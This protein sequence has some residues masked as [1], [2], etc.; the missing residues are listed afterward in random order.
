MLNVFCEDMPG[1]IF[2]ASLYFNN[3]YKDRWITKPLS[4]DM[5]RDVDKSEVIDERAIWSPVFGYM[6]P[7]RLSGG[8][9]TL[10][11]I[12]NDPSHIFSA[13]Y[14]GNNCAK[15]LLKIAEKKVVINL[16]HLMDFGS[17]EFKI[18]VL[19][20]GKIIRNMGDFV[21]GVGDFM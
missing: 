7:T 15:W 10:I 1:A 19:N 14:C 16:W 3:T 9:K 4:R 17:D 13:S 20:T 8:V 11:L 18:R 12:D 2:D 21:F 6:S 5:I